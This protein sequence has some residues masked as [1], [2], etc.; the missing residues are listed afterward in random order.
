V[1]GTEPPPWLS[2]GVRRL[3]PELQRQLAASAESLR[4][5]ETHS[6]EELYRIAGAQLRLATDLPCP[7]PD[8]MTALDLG[9]QRHTDLLEPLEGLFPA[10]TR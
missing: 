1:T 10:G 5:L 9:Q 4:W 2:E 3:D 8:G 6:A 7:F